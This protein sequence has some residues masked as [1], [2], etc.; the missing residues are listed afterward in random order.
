M[1]VPLDSGRLPS[2]I[3][4]TVAVRCDTAPVAGIPP[5][6]VAEEEIVVTVQ[7]HTAQR[8]CRAAQREG[9]A[10][11]EVP[12]FVVIHQ[13]E[14]IGNRGGADLFGVCVESDRQGVG[15]G[16]HINHVVVVGISLAP[17]M[18]FDHLES[19]GSSLGESEHIG[20]PLVGVVDQ[21]HVVLTCVP[22][23]TEHCLRLARYRPCV[24]GPRP[25]RSLEA[26]E[27][28]QQMPKCACHYFKSLFHSFLRIFCKFVFL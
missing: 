8:G 7:L 18:I 5:Q 20:C 11:G 17:S 25:G 14:G 15:A 6:G 9:M 4:R 23:S 16:C 13:V 1:A 3:G 10:G 24:V 12:A 26:K 21:G 2:P 27:Q 19:Y 28:H 22:S